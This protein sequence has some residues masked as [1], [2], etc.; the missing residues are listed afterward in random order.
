MRHLATQAQ[1]VT[2]IRFALFAAM[3]STVACEASQATKSG[4][5]GDTDARD[6]GSEKSTSTDT[7]ENTDSSSDNHGDTDTQEECPHQIN[8][9]YYDFAL[10]DDHPDFHCN[11]A[12]QGITA[13]L[14]LT[15]LD[16][17]RKP[18][19]NP[20]PPAVTGGSNPMITSAQT[21]RDWFHN[22]AAN[23]VSTGVIPLV[24]TPAGSGLFK[25]A[26]DDHVIVPGQGGFTTEI[27]SEFKYKP[28]QVF[29]FLGDDD[30]WVF[31][32]DEL[33]VD[34]GGL[35]NDQTG[36]VDLDELGLIPG[37][38]YSIDMF[39]AERCYPVS[40]FTLETSIDC[41]SPVL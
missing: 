30:V 11:M 7:T 34:I 14:I 3:L 38:V 21:F 25:Y 22:T 36:S 40:H 17:D 12:G 8:V 9:T 5:H 10:E 26:S 31:I 28:G 39:H 2:L 27:H 23:V 24:E 37:E 13:G 20:N 16:K 6:T 1:R 33:V 32:D 19:Y 41:F 15:S 4:T 35:H 29:S 18:I